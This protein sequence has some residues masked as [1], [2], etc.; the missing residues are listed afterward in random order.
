MSVPNPPSPKYP[1]F[2]GVATSPS[3][4]VPCLITRPLNTVL[5]RFF[6]SAKGMLSLQL[7][8]CLARFDTDVENSKTFLARLC[9]QAERYDGT[10]SP[11][12]DYTENC[13]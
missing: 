8:D 10:S 2:Q 1:A 4:K 12:S 13:Y 7:D 11:L 9:E 5:T 6:N 3:T